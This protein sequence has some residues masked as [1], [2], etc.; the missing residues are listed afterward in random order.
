M[1]RWNFGFPITF[2]ICDIVSEVY[3]YS[4]AKAFIWIGIIAELVFSNLSLFINEL[5]R[6]KQ[7]GIN[8]EHL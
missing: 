5:P 3:G 2:I 6:R 8:L 1:T 4:T 7:R